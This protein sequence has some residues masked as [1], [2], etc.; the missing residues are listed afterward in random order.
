[1]K[2][3]SYFIDD[4]QVPRKEFFARLRDRCQ[5]VARTDVIA[6]WCGVD[7]MEFDEKKYKRCLR[8]INDNVE[9]F[10]FGER[11]GKSFRRKEA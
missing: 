9:I 5:R 3:Y 11:T 2:K 6:G 7:I 4:V 10:F 1:M 8:D